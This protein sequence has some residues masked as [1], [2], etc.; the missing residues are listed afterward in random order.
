MG[1]WSNEYNAN[2]AFQDEAWVLT[3]KFIESAIDISYETGYEFADVARGM[4]M[5]IVDFCNK[6]DNMPT[7][8]G[9]IMFEDFLEFVE[10]ECL[11]KAYVNRWREPLEYENVAKEE[12]KQAHKLLDSWKQ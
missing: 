11:S 7:K 1:A 10:K 3:T 2:D 6:T 9:I 12:F 5:T 8:E 4:V